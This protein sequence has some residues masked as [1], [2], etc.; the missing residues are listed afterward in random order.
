MIV[1]KLSDLA[2]QAKLTQSMQKAIAFLESIQA[3]QLEPGRV[4]IDGDR[5]FA[6]V[7]AYDT[8]TSDM[9]FEGHRRYI[10]FQY[11]A[12]GQETLGWAP[13]ESATVTREYDEGRDMWLGTVAA[14]DATPLHLVAGQVAMLF[15]SDAHAPSYAAGESSPVTKIVVKVAL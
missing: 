12:S 9:M 1:A 13:L 10:D 15:P 8:K 2:A 5:V 11:V 4:E 14:T 7:Q 6:L 3:E